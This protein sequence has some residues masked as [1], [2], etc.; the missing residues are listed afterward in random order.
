MMHTCTHVTDIRHDTH[1][2][3]SHTS[4]GLT[5]FSQSVSVR[6]GT[7]RGLTNSHVTITHS[8][9]HLLFA[10]WAR[11]T[12]A[13][14]R[15]SSSTSEELLHPCDCN[16]ARALGPVVE[17]VRREPSDPSRVLRFGVAASVECG[18]AR[19]TLDHPPSSATLQLQ[20]TRYSHRRALRN[21][22][23]KRLSRALLRLGA[24]KRCLWR[25]VG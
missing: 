14:Y 11:S 17:T 8:V 18:A 23:I 3:E 2:Q 19:S 4:V 10:L 13:I 15:F 21:V 20:P 16:L 6:R 5:G 24:K 7:Q 9:P 1:G 22:D 25:K 12:S